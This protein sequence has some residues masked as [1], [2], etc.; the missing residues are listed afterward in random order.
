M[1]QT[2]RVVVV[3]DSALSQRLITAMIERD[4]QIRV[5]GTAR[6]GREALTVVQS[7]RPDVVTMDVRMPVMDGLETT[8]R[9]MAYCPTPIL[10][11]T[12]SLNSHEVD[13]TFKMLGAGALEVIEKPSGTDP[14]ALEQVADR[15]IR[16]IKVL[17]RVKVVTHLR[18]RRHGNEQPAGAIAT[19]P[20]PLPPP[21]RQ[22]DFPVIVIGASTGGPRVIAQILADLPAP[23]PAAL[24]VVQ[25]IAEGFGAGLAEW[26]NVVGRI[27]VVV[28]ATGQVVRPNHVIVAPDRADLVIRPDATLHLTT[29]PL[30]IQKPAIDITM[31]AAA[32]VFK[33]RTIGVLLTGMGR[34]GAAGMLA[35]R[36]AGGHT[37][38]QDSASSAI[39][40]MPRAAIDLNAAVEVL[41]AGR[42]GARLIE[43][44]GSM[45]ATTM[46]DQQ[47][48][49]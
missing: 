27:P 25:H 10:V 42:I 6:D 38:A 40:G 8:E 17:A 47:G 34:D 3:D 26:L 9:L 36:Q 43:L 21:N 32:A 28:A 45:A 1:S 12:A 30:L 37:I 35:I 23:F 39:F 7:L 33:T 13:I 22:P 46:L 44:T 49:Q 20:G 5:V 19:V 24:I 2:I 31:Q 41:P 14:Q 18:G 11:L 29:E 15:L 48:T 16:R 4:P